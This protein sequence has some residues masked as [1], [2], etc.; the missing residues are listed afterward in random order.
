MK[1]LTPATAA[2]LAA[3]MDMSARLLLWIAAR[4]RVSGAAEPFGLW[5]GD[6]DQT[7]VIEGV[8]RTYAG[9]G[10]L[11]S[12]AEIVHSAGLSVR[13][14]RATLSP[15]HPAVAQGFF[16]HDARFAAVELHLALFEPGSAVLIDNP[17][18]A[19]RGTIDAAPVTTPEVG[20]EASFEVAMASGSRDLTRSLAIKKSDES[21]RLRGGDRFRQYAD[22]SGAVPVFWGDGSGYTM[23]TA[24][25]PPSSYVFGGY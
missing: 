16:T 8:T 7:F 5:T 22:V 1:A 23:P 2:W 4:N 20:G 12:V 19:F 13:M 17:R 14:Q 10:G 21:Q 24:A 9:G 18:R 6:Q 25:L 11:I 3:R 15:L